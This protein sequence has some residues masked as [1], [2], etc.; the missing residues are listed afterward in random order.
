MQMFS[1]Q[2]ECPR[3]SAAQLSGQQFLKVT[4]LQDA[5]YAVDLYMFVAIVGKSSALLKF[6]QNTGM[7]GQA[8]A[9]MLLL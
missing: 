1:G 3:R 4:G 6:P 2:P 7:K 8:C 5:L 9:M